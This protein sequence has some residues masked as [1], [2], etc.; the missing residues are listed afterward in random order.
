M[1]V[2]GQLHAP[3]ALL[4]VKEPHIPTHWVDPRVG[5]DDVKKKKF[6]ALTGL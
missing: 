4:P 5:L 1:E 3:P 2:S 6:L